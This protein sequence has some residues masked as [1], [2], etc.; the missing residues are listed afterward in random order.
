MIWRS[1]SSQDRLWDSA[2][3]G[4]QRTWVG[5]GTGF[6]YAVC[7]LEITSADIEH[8]A[9]LS[10]GRILRFHVACFTTCCFTEWI[11]ETGTGGPPQDLGGGP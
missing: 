8:Q 9:E 10:D 6:T 11:L 4:T 3:G 1:R 2:E 5:H 7:D